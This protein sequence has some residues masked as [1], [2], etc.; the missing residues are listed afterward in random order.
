MSKQNLKI[1]NKV[2][3]LKKD[4]LR[5]YIV[6][7]RNFTLNLP[8][9]YFIQILE[10]KKTEQLRAIKDIVLSLNTNVAE[11]SFQTYK[12]NLVETSIDSKPPLFYRVNDIDTLKII[13]QAAHAKIQS[14]NTEKI[15]INGLKAFLKYHAHQFPEYIIND[16]LTSVF[17]MDIDFNQVIDDDTKYK[18]ELLGLD[19]LKD[20][21]ITFFAQM[22]LNLRLLIVTG[23]LLW[24][25]FELELIERFRSYNEYLYFPEEEI[26]TFEL[27]I[28]KILVT[29]LKENVLNIKFALD[30]F[31]LIEKIYTIVKLS[32]LTVEPWKE[33]L[34]G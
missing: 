33:Y 16:V 34:Y 25:E 15:I 12:S 23:F 14:Y 11:E 10:M 2:K 17:S 1:F 9:E 18:H 31:S 13:L 32:S 3:G 5:E 7:L 22:E 27:E 26:G 21:I 19:L 28:Y 6:T 24:E 20:S 8:E 30:V 4:Q 29:I